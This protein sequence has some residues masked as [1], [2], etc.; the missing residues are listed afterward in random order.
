MTLSSPP[1]THTHSNEFDEFNGQEP[2]GWIST[3]GNDPDFPAEVAWLSRSVTFDADTTQGSNGYKSWECNSGQRRIGGHMMISHTSV[4]QRIEGVEFKNFGQSGT[5]GKYVSATFCV[6][7]RNIS[8]STERLIPY[9]ITHFSSSLLHRS[10]PL[11]SVSSLPSLDCHGCF[12]SKTLVLV[13]INHQP[14]HF[15]LCGDVSGSIVRKNL[16]RSSHQR[17]VVIH[18]S[19]NVTVEENVS[20]GHKGHCYMT[21][22]GV[23]TGNMFRGNLGADGQRLSCVEFLLGNKDD[24]QASTYW[25]SNQNNQL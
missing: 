4:A 10:L 22:D 25:I 19:H 2:A 14:I 16:V 24:K 21:E 23:E 17:C 7:E 12:V 8:R 6:C 13:P 20:F 11:L 3:L 18:R 5:L 15:H 1:T 9:K